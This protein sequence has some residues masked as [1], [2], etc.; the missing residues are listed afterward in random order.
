MLVALG[1]QQCCVS[2]RHYF[3]NIILIMTIQGD[4]NL[5]L[6]RENYGW[7]WLAC[8]RW[9]WAG[10]RHDWNQVLK[11]YCQVCLSAP[12][13]ASSQFL[14]AAFFRQDLSH[15]TKLASH[16]PSYQPQ[17]EEGLP[18]PKHTFLQAPERLALLGCCAH[19]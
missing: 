2:E 8:A 18:C 19:P 5:A 4:L 3:G 10:F 11:Q 13:L 17:W 15:V 1:A 9:E 14:L 6:A 16:P 7:V 12:H